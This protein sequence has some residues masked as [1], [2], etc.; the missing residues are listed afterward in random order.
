[1]YGLSFLERGGVQ[2]ILALTVISVIFA[3]RMKPHRDPLS[4]DGPNAAVGKG[5]QVVFLAALFLAAAYVIYDVWRLDFLAKV[6]PISVA[7]VT[8]VLVAIAALQ[9]LR[10]TP[11]YVFFDGE[12][13]W[14]DADKPHHSDLHYQGWILGLLAL[15]GLV[16]FILAIFIYIVTFLRVKAAVSWRWAVLGALGAVLVLGTFGHVLALSYP[17]GLLQMMTDLPWPFD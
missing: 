13:E 1:V 10:K 16:G 2:F 11:D 9:F 7:V 8:L 6:F 5:P 14:G 4:A 3:L 12:R 17:R 15:I